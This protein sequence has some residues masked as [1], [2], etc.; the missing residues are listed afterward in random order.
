VPG[1]A[2]FASGLAN[3]A[4]HYPIYKVANANANNDEALVRSNFQ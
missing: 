1:F 4:K 2:D 3:A